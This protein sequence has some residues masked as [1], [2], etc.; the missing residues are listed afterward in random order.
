MLLAF[1]TIVLSNCEKYRQQHETYFFSNMDLNASPLTLFIDGENKGG[2]PHFKTVSSPANDTILKNALK[3]TL[4]SGKY[5]MEAKDIQ[6]NL[7]CAANIKFT[8]NKINV[9][10]TLGAVSV[11]GSGS[12]VIIELRQ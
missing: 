3:L 7:K 2:V 8:N 1:T 4:K 6:G 10:S 5:K 11:L 12:E 9:T